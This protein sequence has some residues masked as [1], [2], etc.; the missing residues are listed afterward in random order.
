M[1][2]RPFID[3]DAVNLT[4]FMHHWGPEAQG[5]P[6]ERIFEQIQ[7][8]RKNVCRKNVSGDWFLAVEGNEI[9][10][11]LQMSR[12]SLVGFLPAA[13][14]S[15]LQ[16]HTDYRGRGIGTNLIE[17]VRTWAVNRGLKRLLLSS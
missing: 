2:I 14:I 6:P 9:I 4:K 8:C 1:K 13:E 12:S 3:T 15:A 7:H 5:L 10:A 11:Y 17:Y 16:L